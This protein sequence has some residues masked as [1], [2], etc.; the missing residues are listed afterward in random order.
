MSEGQKLTPDALQQKLA[1]FAKR[2]ADGKTPEIKKPTK[3]ETQELLALEALGL[4][5]IEESKEYPGTVTVTRLAETIEDVK[6]ITY[7]SWNKGMMKGDLFIPNAVI[8]DRRL[9]EID[10]Y[11]FAY[12]R[13]YD[14]MDYSLFTKLVAKNT[15]WSKGQIKKSLLRLI[16]VA[17]ITNF[18]DEE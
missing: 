11:V 9:T 18:S 10:W 17:A 5:R 4:V 8:K 16:K 13:K 12:I 6:R 3:D 15:K 2:K 7:D 14:G 1:E